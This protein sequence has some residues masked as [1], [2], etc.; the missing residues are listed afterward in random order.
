MAGASNHRSPVPLSLMPKLTPLR[1]ITVTML[2]KGTLWA[3]SDIDLQAAIETLRKKWSFPATNAS[4]RRTTPESRPQSMRASV[5]RLKMRPDAAALRLCSS[6]PMCRAC[7][8]KGFRSRSFIAPTA[9]L[10]AVKNSPPSQRSRSTTSGEFAPKRRT[11]PRPSLRLLKARLPAVAFSTTQTG[12]EG[13]MT[14]AIGPTAP[15]A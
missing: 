11:L 7:A 2:L 13:L 6:S 12:M 10:I 1:V 3:A 5:S 9:A 15:C 14:P 8:I 4:A